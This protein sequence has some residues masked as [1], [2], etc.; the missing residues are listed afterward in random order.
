MPPRRATGCRDGDGVSRLYSFDP[1]KKALR[2]ELGNHRKEFLDPILIG[3]I[4]HFGQ[5]V[6]AFRH[7]GDGAEPA[8]TMVMQRPLPQRIAGHQQTAPRAVPK[9]KGV[10]P[11]ET[12]ETSIFPTF[13]GGEEDGGVTEKA[14]AGRG[15]LQGFSQLVAVVQAKIGDEYETAATT[16]Q[17]LVVEHVLRQHPHQ[18]SADRNVSTGPMPPPHP[19][20]TSPGPQACEHS[21]RPHPAD[22]RNATARQWRSFYGQ[23]LKSRRDHEHHSDILKC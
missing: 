6:Q 9:N 20:H 23:G 19:V 16:D 14:R 15:D 21:L 7:A 13:D 3:R 2:A 1:A 5:G 17:R 10:V 18:L 22:R 8:T 11:D 12:R 4:R